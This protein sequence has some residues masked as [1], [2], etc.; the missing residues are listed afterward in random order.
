MV[1]KIDRPKNLNL[2][3]ETLKSGHLSIK[4]T[5]NKIL[6]HFHWPGLKSDVS[7]FCFR[8]DALTELGAFMRTQFLCIYVLRVA[9]GP[10]VK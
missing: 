2:A 8:F 3:H 5:Y 1:P 9:S 4:K 10:R 6:Y 7:Q